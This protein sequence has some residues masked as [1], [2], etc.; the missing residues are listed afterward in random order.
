MFFGLFRDADD[1]ISEFAAPSGALEGAEVIVAWYDYEDYDGNAFVLFRRES[2]LFEVHGGHCSCYGLEGQWEPEKTTLAY[3]ARMV[4]EETYDWR[5]L[6]G[7][8]QSRIKDLLGRQL[9]LLD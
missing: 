4:A 9:V 6:P 1:V 2:E 8:A 3:L 7:A 5:R